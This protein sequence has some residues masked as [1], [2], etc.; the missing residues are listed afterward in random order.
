MQ[1]E[2]GTV[3]KTADGVVGTSGKPVRIYALHILSGG[4]AGE[5]KLKSGTSSSGT[6]YVQE[7]CTVV[8]TG[9]KFVYGEHGVL[10]PSGCYYE[11]VTDANVVSTAISFEIEA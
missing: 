3:L 1:G 5:V 2:V 7:L 8:S 4:T 11:E 10:F 9:N 6:I